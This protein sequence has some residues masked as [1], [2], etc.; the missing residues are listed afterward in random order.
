MNSKKT[1][2]TTFTGSISSII[3]FIATCC[4]PGCIGVCGTGCI[5][6]VATILGISTSGIFASVWWEV[7]QPIFMVISAVFFTVAYYTIYRQPKLQNSCCGENDLKINQK[8]MK[9]NRLLKYFFWIALII[10]IDM[11]VYSIYTKA[12]SHRETT[13]PQSTGNTIDTLISKNTTCAKDTS[14]SCVTPCK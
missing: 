8:I 3:T 11:F 5:L 7:L 12:T 2:W 10:S 9:K 14:K 1:L 6:P 13:L 4:G